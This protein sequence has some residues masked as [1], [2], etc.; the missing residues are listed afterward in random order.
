MIFFNKEQKINNKIFQT[1]T[2]KGFLERIEKKTFFLSKSLWRKKK[3]TFS[4]SIRKVLRLLSCYMDLK[5]LKV[6]GI[7]SKIPFFHDKKQ[8]MGSFLKHVVTMKKNNFILWYSFFLTLETKNELFKENRKKVYEIAN[9]NKNF[10][11]N[12]WL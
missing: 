8:Q 4:K 7:L 2:K 6:K 10:A 5:D 9:K 1:L 11:N 12:F 3:V